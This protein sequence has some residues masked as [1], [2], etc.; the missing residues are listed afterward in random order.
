MGIIKTDAEWRAASNQLKLDDVYYGT[1]GPDAGKAILT[2]GI[3]RLGPDWQPLPG[4]HTTPAVEL[5]ALPQ[6][7]TNVLS[8]IA[9]LSAKVDGLPVAVLNQT[10][11]LPDGT[12]TNLAGILS[13]IHAAPVAAPGTFT[14][15][16]ALVVNA[17]KAQWNK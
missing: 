16:P 6:N 1:V 5:G 17:I 8:A 10:F 14:D 3:D 11:A 4:V 7:F 13:A 2:N 12:V 9:A 15:D